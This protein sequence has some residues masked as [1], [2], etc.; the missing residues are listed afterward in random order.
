MTFSKEL[1]TFAG[2]NLDFYTC[3]NDYY[4][5]EKARTPENAEKINKAF[6]AELEKRSGVARTEDNANAWAANP[7]VQWASFAIIDALVNSVLPQV[8]NESIGIFTDLRG[9]GYGD[10]V[11]Y[12]VRPRQLFTVS[13]G[14][15]GER[16]SVRQKQY[17]GD[18][19][20]APVEH[21]VTVYV[22][23]Y[24]VL[25]GKEDI[26]EFVKLV[27]LSIEREMEMDAFKAL[28]AGLNATTYPNR[29][30]VAGAFD[31]STLITLIDNV[32]AY[33]YGV[34]PVVLG[35]ATALSKV[36]PD[37]TLGFRG[38]W[39]ASNGNIQLVKNFYGADL[40]V[41]PQFATDLDPHSTTPLA[42]PDDKLFIVSPGMDKLVKGVVSNQMTNTNQY[43]DNADLTQNYTM[44][45]DWNFDF[46]SAAWGA[47]YTLY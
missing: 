26:A 38:N 12:K 22:D 19:I 16:T 10:V 30:K 43:F 11:K 46:L 23:F 14:A 6:F 24:S 2:D 25:C 27:V 5:N 36:T 13:K 15:H 1:I 45:K 31:A 20:V 18:M 29:F 34:K 32:K 17:D 9:V 35:T 37:S 41:L 40:M 33:N 44:R 28:M 39:D 7:Q 21:I 8:L 3:F 4:M 42:L 47:T